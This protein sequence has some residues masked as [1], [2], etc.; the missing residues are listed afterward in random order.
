MENTLDAFSTHFRKD[1]VADGI[2]LDV[3]LTLDG[4]V[5]VFHD[6][7]LSRLFPGDSRRIR[8]TK[9]PDLPPS[10][11]KL[12]DVFDLRRS[13]RACAKIVNVELKCSTSA[14]DAFELYRKVRRQIATE[15]NVLLSSF[16]SVLLSFADVLALSKDVSMG[17]NAIVPV[18]ENAQLGM[19]DVFAE[20]ADIVRRARPRIVISDAVSVVRDAV[21]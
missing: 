6:T 11:P 15:S 14:D 7:D 4:V 13:M 9:Y 19:Y 21:I 20:H 17:R 16:S 2:E 1:S 8:D 12:S 18:S 3:R 5:V 10:I